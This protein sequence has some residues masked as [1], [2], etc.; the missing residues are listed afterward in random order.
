MNP[1]ERL[2]QLVDVTLELLRVHG[3]GV[4]T[5]QIAERA[6]VAE[7]TIFRVVETKDELVDAA[8]ARAFRPGRVEDRILEIDDTL[9]LHDRLVLLVGILQ[10]RFRATFALMQ[11]VGMIRPP[12]HLHDGEE[13]IAIRARMGQVLE[14]VVGADADALNVPVDEFVHRLRLLTFAG[15]HDHIA[16]GRLLTP[17]QIVDTLLNGLARNT[18]C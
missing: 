4:T 18:P 7:G 3:R 12:D 8:I 11:K 6:G 10:Q 16:D 17:E 1:E 13:A 9:P 15:S 5:R 2:D 14:A